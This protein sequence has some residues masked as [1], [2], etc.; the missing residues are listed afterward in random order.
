MKQ[1]WSCCYLAA[2]LASRCVSLVAGQP[3]LARYQAAGRRRNTRRTLQAK[4]HNTICQA[5]ATVAAVTTKTSKTRSKCQ[6]FSFALALRTSFLLSWGVNQDS[7]GTTEAGKLGAL[8]H[9][10]HNHWWV[11]LLLDQLILGFRVARY[12]IPHGTPVAFKVMDQ[13]PPSN[14]RTYTE[15]HRSLD[16]RHPWIHFGIQIHGC[17]AF[18]VL[19]L[20]ATGSELAAAAT[21]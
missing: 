17:P 19:V 15:R 3:S 2:D 6:I 18:S 14:V 5:Q 7:V 20:F 9:K 21:S 8:Q 11:L 1:R 12:L 4:G 10:H 13:K 16:P